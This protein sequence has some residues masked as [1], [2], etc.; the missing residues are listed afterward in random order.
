MTFINLSLILSFF[1]RS[2]SIF[3]ED[4]PY[5]D[6]D[7]TD[8]PMFGDSKSDYEEVVGQFYG[9][10]QSYCTPRSFVWCEKYDI[11]EAPDRNVRRAMEKE[12]KKLK[13]KAKK[14]RNEEIR[15]RKLLL[16]S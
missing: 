8:I 6:E 5:Y 16:K 9:F 13:D 14:E 3:K 7:I 10:W 4:R 11:R 15:V 2:L 1:S 12:N